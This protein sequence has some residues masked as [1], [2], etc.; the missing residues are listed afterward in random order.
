M[1]I[2]A[3]KFDACYLGHYG[4]ADPGP[5][6]IGVVGA[7]AEVEEASQGVRV[8]HGD[9]GEINQ[10]PAVS[11]NEQLLGTLRSLD[12]AGLKFLEQNQINNKSYWR[13]QNHYIYDHHNRIT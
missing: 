3:N 7:G 12:P 9:L 8:R 6:L 5:N 13:L 11:S 1:N 2:K 4:E 10:S